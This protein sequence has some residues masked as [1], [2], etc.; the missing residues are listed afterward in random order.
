MPWRSVAGDSDMLRGP[1]RQC[2]LGGDLQGNVHEL[3]ELRGVGEGNVP[4]RR[5]RVGKVL[6]WGAAQNV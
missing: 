2:H 6:G 1:L 5:K 3:D 4:G